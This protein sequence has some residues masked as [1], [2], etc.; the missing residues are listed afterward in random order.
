MT[1]T[2][3]KRAGQGNDPYP[4]FKVFMGVFSNHFAAF[5]IRKEEYRKNIASKGMR[6]PN[7]SALS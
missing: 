4:A 6:P 5:H 1:C 7:I 3:H 2:D